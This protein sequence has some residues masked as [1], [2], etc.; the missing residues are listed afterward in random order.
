MFII[1]SEFHVIR[2]ITVGILEALKRPFAALV[3]TEISHGAI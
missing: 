2:I 1:L 3:L